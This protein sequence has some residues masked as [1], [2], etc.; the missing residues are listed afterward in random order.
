MMTWDLLC[1]P[2]SALNSRHTQLWSSVIRAVPPGQV[3]L[4]TIVL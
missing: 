3:V 1:T 4:T 2:R